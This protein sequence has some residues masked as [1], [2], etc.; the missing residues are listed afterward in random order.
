MSFLRRERAHQI[1]LMADQFAKEIGSQ[2][3]YYMIFE[4]TLYF[5]LIWGQDF[6]SVDLD[7]VSRG[8]RINEIITIKHSEK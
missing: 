7:D 2:F 8:A 3:Y 1:S 6:E 4:K 5:P